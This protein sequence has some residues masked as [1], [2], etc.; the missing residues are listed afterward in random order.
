MNESLKTEI[1]NLIKLEGLN[2][3]VEEFKDKVSWY[4]ISRYQKLSEEFIREFKDKVEWYWTSR[5]QKLSEEFI[6]EFKDKVDWSLISCYQKLS[7]EFIRE[8]KDKVYW[9]E[10]SCYQKLSEEFIREFKDKVDWSEISCNQKLSEEFIRE[11]KDQVNWYG[12]SCSQKLSE[13]FIR[14]FKDKVEWS[15]ISYSQKLSEEFIREFKL[16][17]DPDNWL[18]WTD[19]QKI[20]VIKNY[21][22]IDNEGFIVA[23]KGIRSDRYSKY[24]FQFHYE[25]GQTYEAHCDCTAN[26]N[27][28]GL[29]AWTKEKASE[30]CNE[31]VVRV[32]I[33]V[34]DIG[35][36]V[37]D[38]G[39]I[40]CFKQT[41]LD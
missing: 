9:S 41:F 28:F 36:I 10:I 16:T 5:Y 30:Y 34:S 13:E 6:R 24:N 11:F 33:H 26:E 2:C 7:E 38:G 18:Y 15:R 22:D 3:T 8:F 19:E 23:W 21:Y 37:H 32:K 14:E 4:N 1:I 25:K 29:S 40:R 31:L 39:K 12:I 20:S 27:S 17:I 35:R